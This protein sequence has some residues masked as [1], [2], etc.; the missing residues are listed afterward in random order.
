MSRRRHL[1]SGFAALLLLGSCG[2]G[3]GGTP[4]PSPTPSPTPTPTNRAPS[5]TSA[6]T[7]SAA[8]NSGGTIYTATASDPDG[9]ALTFSI[10]GGADAA[11]RS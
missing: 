2:G 7:V 1:V 11:P 10:A 8:E 5:F 6:S 4:S 9:D 3:G